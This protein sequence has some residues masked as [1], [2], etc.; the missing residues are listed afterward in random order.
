M[1]LADLAN[2][3]QAKPSS[4]CGICYLL[5]TLPKDGPNGADALDGAL[6]NAA[7]TFTEIST[8][9]LNESG[10]TVDSQTIS[11]HAQG[12]CKARRRYR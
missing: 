4:E 3:P 10:M 8:D 1:A 11:R 7:V 12:G 5:R 6:G 9:L 2:R